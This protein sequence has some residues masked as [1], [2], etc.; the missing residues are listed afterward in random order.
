MS[1][2]YLDDT[3][4]D[5]NDALEQVGPTA[6]ECNWAAA[7]HLGG[8]FGSFLF[9]L[10]VGLLKQEQS[11]L[12]ARH[13]REAF[14]F[15]LLAL[16]GMILFGIIYRFAN[17]FLVLVIAWIFFEVV[18]VVL[19]ALAASQGRPYRYPVSLRVWR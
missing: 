16:A 5:S 11:P 14:N 15:Q 13:A 3:D 8:L 4:D 12:I 10:I 9:P 19:A 17:G 6:W 18:F 2:P 1:H 7:V